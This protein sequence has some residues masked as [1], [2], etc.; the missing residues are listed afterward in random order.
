MVACVQFLF[1]PAVIHNFFF[2]IVSHFFLR[3]MEAG[4]AGADGE[5]VWLAVRDLLVGDN[6]VSQDVSAALALAA[7]SA[8]EAR[9]RWLAALCASSLREPAAVRETLRRAADGP[10]DG[11]GALALSL[12]AALAG[13]WAWDE[14][15]S[16]RRAAERGEPF[17]Q[18][19]REKREER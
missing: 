12:A 3:E 10:D 1:R 4:K 14:D 16:T 17:A 9:C 19:R 5:D 11:F 18:V 15:G 7:S 2:F 6:C 13:P 8:H